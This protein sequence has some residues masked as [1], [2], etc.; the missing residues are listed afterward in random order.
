[1]LSIDAD[2]LIKKYG[3]WYVEDV[4]GEGFVGNMRGFVY[5]VVRPVDVPERKV[6]TWINDRGLYRCSSCN[7]LWAEWWAASKPIERM[8]KECPYCPMCGSYNGEEIDNGGYDQ[9]TSG[10]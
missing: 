9:Q 2:E 5:D 4:T 6:G 7:Q 8:K 3:D 10:D 1:M